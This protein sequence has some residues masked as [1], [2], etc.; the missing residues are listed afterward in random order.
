YLQPLQDLLRDTVA[1]SYA[2]HLLDR[3][4][5]IFLRQSQSMPEEDRLL[6][7]TVARL[8]IDAKL[9]IR[10]Q[11]CWRERQLPSRKEFARK[12]SLPPGP[13]ETV[14]LQ[15]WNGYGGFNRDG[16]EYVIRLREGINTP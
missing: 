3:P 4:G 12:R 2:R 6:F 13:E 15:L 16:K 5:G 10:A 8:V 1:I 11:L 9:Q 7:F 14:D